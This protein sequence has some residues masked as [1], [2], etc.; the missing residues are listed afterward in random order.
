[1]IIVVN[2]ISTYLLS[3]LLPESSSD[4]SVTDLFAALA[5]NPGLLV[6]FVGPLFL[7]GAV[8]EE[9]IRVFLL[10][11]L[12]RVWPSTA[13]KLL[14]IV[15]SACLFGLIHSYQGPVGAAWTAILA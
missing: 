9:V 2:V 8:S 10:S 11:R 7:L 15:I 3:A 13:G 14:T 4:T 5:G 1:V 12:W 6:L